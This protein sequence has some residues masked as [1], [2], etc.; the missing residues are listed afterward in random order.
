M[1]ILFWGLVLFD[2]AI[3]AISFFVVREHLEIGDKYLGRDAANIIS[4]IFAALLFVTVP[5]LAGLWVFGWRQI[6]SVFS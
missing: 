2:I 1:Q 5:S 6:L 4:C 3:T